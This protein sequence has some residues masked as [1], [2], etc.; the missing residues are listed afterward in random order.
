MSGST[1][2]LIREHVCQQV[3]DV[4]AEGNVYATRVVDARDGKA[5][6]NVFFADG[7]SGYEGLQLIHTAELVIGIHLPWADN[8]D[9]DLDD[10]ADVVAELFQDD[11]SITLD[12]IVAGFIYTGFEYGEEDD[13]PFIHIYSKYQVQY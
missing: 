12:N 5:Y 9:N 8:S 13:S 7:Q 11:P 2:R 10:Y 3:Q 1:R 6:G 4:F